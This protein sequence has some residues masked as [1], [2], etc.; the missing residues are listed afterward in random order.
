MVA[1]HGGQ[2][3]QIIYVNVEHLNFWTITEAMQQPI[4]CNLN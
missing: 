1:R 2:N 3:K 4:D